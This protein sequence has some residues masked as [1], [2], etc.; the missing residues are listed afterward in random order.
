MSPTISFVIP[1][2]NEEEMFL[3]ALKQLRTKCDELI[4]KNIISNKSYILFVDDG[5]KDRTWSLIE[6]ACS[7]FPDIHGLKLTRNFGHQSALLAGLNA[8]VDK[9]DAC[10]CMDADLQQDISV[11]EQF[12]HHFNDGCEI[13][14]GIK[15]N[16]RHDRFLKRILSKN[17]YRLMKLM[18]TPII[19]EHP[20]FRLMGQ[21]SLKSL[22]SF[23]EKNLFL[24][25]LMP[26]LG[27]KTA[28]VVF[29]LKKREAGKAKYRII[30]SV[31]LAFNAITA[32]STV[33]LR[34]ITLMGFIITIICFF[35]SLDVI[36]SYYRGELVP[37]WASIMFSI[38]FLGGIQLLSIGVVGE[39]IA[40]IYAETKDRPHYLIEKEISKEF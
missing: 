22:L 13:V 23:K 29:T 35:L 3:L 18:G 7:K 30:D 39:Y 1:C 38:F 16:R 15:K 2:Y 17:F 36:R 8:V 31:K 24:R 12:I 32:S 9:C 28:K 33:P 19:E 5:S 14:Y 40:R 21:N 25:G 6:D 27:F 10:L 37:G 34:M 11:L 26:L 4:G 20:D